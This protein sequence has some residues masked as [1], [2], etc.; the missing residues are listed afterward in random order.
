MAL[1]HEAMGRRAVEILL[2]E[3]SH[4]E[5]LIEMPAVVRA[6]VAPARSDATRTRG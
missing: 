4:G 2:D 1:P 6:S 3:G 5:T